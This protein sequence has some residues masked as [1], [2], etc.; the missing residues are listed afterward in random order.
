MEEP[1][2]R[3]TARL[4]APMASPTTS[5]VSHMLPSLKGSWHPDH[6]PTRILRLNT[7]ASAMAAPGK[8]TAQRAAM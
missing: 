1:R 6:H 2:V 8:V 5:S 4:L 3:E 7:T